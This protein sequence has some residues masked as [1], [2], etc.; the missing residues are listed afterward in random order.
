MLFCG[1]DGTARD[2][3]D[4][5]GPN[6]PVVGIPGGVKMHS[7]VFAIHPEEAADLVESFL[8]SGRTSKA[9]VVD[10]DEGAFRAG[11]SRP[12]L[13]AVATVPDDEA[14]LQPTKSTYEGTDA[15]AEADELGGYIAESMQPGVLYI[16][17]PGSTTEAVAR[18]IDK[19]KTLLG[20]DAYVDR[21]IV[22]RDL[23]EKDILR[24]LEEHE[25]RMIIVTPIGAQ[26]FVF[27]RGNQQ[28]SAQ[29]LRAVG[30]DRVTV[31]ATPTKLRST[32]VLRV[33]TGNAELDKAF[34]RP[35]KVITARGRRKLVRVV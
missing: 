3:V 23:A 18:A 17:G 6:T 15:A 14:H 28:L 34:K 12:R 2:V 1:G 5:V 7:S 33:D 27:G 32:P 16:I 19:D 10:V 4:A 22:G 26:G 8:R 21:E 35:F 25:D 31:I 20:V 13:Y 30:V 24:L 9:E 11:I 29:V